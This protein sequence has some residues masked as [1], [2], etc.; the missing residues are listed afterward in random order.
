MKNSVSAQ[1]ANAL[2][3]E[4]KELIKTI[5][6]LKAL[7]PDKEEKPVIAT[8]GLMNAGKSYLLNMLSKHLD[9]EYF[10]TN[11]I[12]ETAQIKEL[13]ESDYIYL[14]TPGLDANS[15]DNAE[16]LKGVEQADVVLFVHQLQGELEQVEIDFLEGVAKSFGEFAQSHIIMVISKIDKEE[17]SKV[18]EIQ[19]KILKQCQEFLGFEPKCFQVSNTRYHKGEKEHKNSLIS[20]SHIL[21]LKAHIEL[22][23]DEDEIEELREQRHKQK[24][25]GYLDRLEEIDDELE[26]YQKEIFDPYYEALVEAHDILTDDIIP[27]LKEF[28]EEYDDV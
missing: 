2:I 28:K 11:D 15:A 1:K 22:M 18:Y 16:A 14:D 9:D 26:V 13:E 24:L 25:I 19:E 20:H 5:A 4:S 3:D 10:K 23:L 17:E 12:R 27:R 21:E 6:K 7:S 8:W